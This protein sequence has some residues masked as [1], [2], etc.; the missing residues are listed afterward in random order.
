MKKVKYW[1]VIIAFVLLIM[2]G[3]ASIGKTI[4]IKYTG[5]KI[6]AIVRRIPSSCDRYNHINVLFNNEDYEVSISRTECREGFYKIGQK[7][8]FLRNKKYKE[9]VWPESHPEL[10]PILI[11]TVFV[12]AYI[13]MRGRNKK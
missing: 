5:E 8:I 11:I 4:F 9:L 2:W 6:E 3:G 12:L 1:I 10:L 13:S 7:I